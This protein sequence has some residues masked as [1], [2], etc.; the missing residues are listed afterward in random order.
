MRTPTSGPR[1]HNFSAGPAILPETVLEQAA[2]AALEYEGKGMSLME[3][4]HRGPE[5]MAIQAHAK[6]RVKELANLTDDYEVLF[7]TGGASSQFFMVPMNLLAD[8]ETAV[9]LDTGT[10]SAKAI[11]EAKNFGNVVV[12]ASS[13]EDNYRHI[14]KNFD[15]P[16][17][18][19]Y[20]H[21]TT[22]NT[23]FGTQF[24][25]A[26]ESSFPLIADMSSDMFSRPIDLQKYGLIYAG[27]QKNLGPAGVTLVI[28]RKD[29][30]GKVE[31]TIPTMLNY[32]THIAKD[33]MFNTPPTYPIYLL[34]LTLDWIVETG[35]LEKMHVRN[36]EKA[37]KLYAEIDRN[38]LFEGTVAHADRSLMNVTFAPTNEAH[39]KPFLALCDEHNISG[40][41]GHRSVGGF[42][43]SIYNA[44]PETSIDAL[45][46][47]MQTF[48]KQHG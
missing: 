26:P 4:S 24:Q 20:L 35:G 5:F 30:L 18:A 15:L 10:W 1:I 33:S 17:S 32:S 23:I 19:T 12:A 2:Q 11:K 38:P 28:I 46:N 45:I 44:M 16:K 21:Y 14:P 40:L 7:L 25:T 13:K 47:A 22:N 31:R 41:K 37:A 6:Q 36:Q 39:Q 42:R 8:T 34:M 9:Y 48:T 43:A 3:M 27:A 29:L